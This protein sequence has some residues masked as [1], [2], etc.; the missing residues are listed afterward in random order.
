[1]K[2]V[3]IY[4]RVS[5]EQQK[6]DDTIQSQIAAVKLRVEQD[7]HILLPQALYADDG[8]SGY[9]LM[10]PE[11]ERLRDDVAAGRIDIIYT[12][13]PDR[14]ARKYAYQVLILEEIHNY[15][16]SVVFLQGGTAESPEGELLIQVQGMI[17]EYE[18]AKSLE[19]SRRG[20]LYKARRGSVNPL[21][22]APYGYQY[23]KK[24]DGCEAS[25]QIILSE[26]KVV[27]RVFDSLVKKQKSIGEIVR[28]L[29]RDAIATKRGAAQWDRSTVWAMLHNPAYIGKAAYGK[30]EQAE[31][32]KLLRPIRN[33][34]PI[35]HRV[36][37]T[38]RDKPV[39]Q[40]IYIDVPA[41]VSPELFQAAKK[42]LQ[43]NKRLSQRHGRGD[44]Y[45]LQGLTVCSRCGYA[46][47]GKTV[48]KSA[49]KGGRRY[50]YYR[51]VGSD[52]YRF[53]GGRVC[54]NTQVRVEQLD[55]YVWE[56]V[57]ELM[58]HPQRLQQEW[59]RRSRNG[60]IAFEQRKQ[61]DES[62][63]IVAIQERTLKRLLDAYEAGLIELEELKS[64][65]DAVRSRI[66]TARKELQKAEKKLKETLQLSAIVT[67]IE[68]FSERVTKRLDKLTWLEKRQIIR[69]LV[70]RV[71][72]DQESATVVYQLPVLAPSV[73]SNSTAGSGTD[74]QGRSKSCLLRGRGDHSALR[75]SRFSV[76]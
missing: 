23:I 25:Y 11:L 49:A 58:Q 65:S 17:A 72:I 56:S 2:S 4:A 48:S 46:Y 73:Q 53:A 7:G 69:T 55:G 24:S 33:R 16:V 67:R 50:A 52:S 22:G 59:S 62:A 34:N 63:R 64:R 6:Q 1:M 3:A 26:A 14:I 12:L 45:L 40:W 76:Y 39:E 19:R 42:Q 13:N 9:I 54:H 20:K 71:E 61:R 8:Y 38:H 31:R 41:I 47:Y 32:R 51:C 57:K 37:S 28:C 70:A 60:G 5:S 36:H 30:T 68:D 21:S 74:D 44:K 66:R 15:G 29:N 35:A 18:R 43:R 10:R 75:R 27:R